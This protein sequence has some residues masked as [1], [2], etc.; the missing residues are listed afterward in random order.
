[1]AINETARESGAFEACTMRNHDCFCVRVYAYSN[2]RRV[3]EQAYMNGKPVSFALRAGCGQE[4][5]SRG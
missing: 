1:M 5:G 2:P 3:A 4:T